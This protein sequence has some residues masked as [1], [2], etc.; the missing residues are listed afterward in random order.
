MKIVSISV[1]ISSSTAVAHILRFVALILKLNKELDVINRFLASEEP[2]A[3]ATS[4]VEKSDFFIL[5]FFGLDLNNNQRDLGSVSANDPKRTSSAPGHMSTA[6]LPYQFSLH[7][8]FYAHFLKISF[9]HRLIPGLR[10]TRREFFEC[11]GPRD[12]RPIYGN[13]HR[14]PAAGS[15]RR[16]SPVRGTGEP[17]PRR[18]GGEPVC[19]ASG[20][21]RPGPTR[22]CRRITR[23]WCLCAGEMSVWLPRWRSMYARRMIPVWNSGGRDEKV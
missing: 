16:A 19:W 6:V 20:C 22:S 11:V 9:H 14:A 15:T 21:R 10:L 23:Q 7:M 4:T 5:F 2:S 13:T 1:K 8:V 12:N 17:G 3:T 18:Y